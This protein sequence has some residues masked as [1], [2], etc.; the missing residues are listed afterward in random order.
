VSTAPKPQKLPSHWWW[1]LSTRD[2]ATL[3]LSGVVAIQPVGA[4]EQHGPHL[5]VCVDAAINVAVIDRAVS[6]MQDTTPILVL[7]PTSVGKS[8]EHTA[9]PGTL[10][11]SHETLTNVWLDIGASVHRAG[12]QRLLFLNSHGGQ[13][14]IV[15]IVCREL[16]IRHGILAVGT[17]WSRITQQDDLFDA[18]ERRH[19]IHG[20]EI[21]TSVMLAAYP[22]LVKMQFAADFTPLSV[23]MEK[24]GGLLTPEGAVGFGW[25]SQDLRP[26]GAC[27]NAAAADARRGEILINRAARALLK[28]CDEI[29]AFPMER[30]RVPPRYQSPSTGD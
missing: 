15:D 18:H 10:T 3:D 26:E 25:Q 19:G 5:P 6:L 16:R 14:Q 13:P 27:G 28:L 11:L 22:D 12:V 8:T 1:D 30:L 17:M 2:F 7:P 9:F 29:A 23:E 20:G 21:E 4:V 24:A